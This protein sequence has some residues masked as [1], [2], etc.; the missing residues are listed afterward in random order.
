M[1]SIKFIKRICIRKS[2]KH[3]GKRMLIIHLL[4]NGGIYKWLT[5]YLWKVRK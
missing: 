2:S 3:F 1:Y 4:K 5:I